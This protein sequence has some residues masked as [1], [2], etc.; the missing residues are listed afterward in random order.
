MQTQSPS[1]SIEELGEAFPS[2]LIVILYDEAI[3]NLEA[4]IDAI[5]KGDIEARFEATAKVADIVS[6]LY[7]ALDLDQGGEIAENL[8]N[9]YNFILTQ[10]QRVNFNDDVDMARQAIGL[11]EPIR[12]SWQELD[13]RI[14]GEVVDAEISTY[15][16]NSEGVAVT[17]K[18]RTTELPV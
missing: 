18:A 6:Q 15:A 1:K 3:A 12:E 2:T 10:L 7:L 8:G 9:I 11:L 16:G 4:A 13:A 17:A 5:E 14:R